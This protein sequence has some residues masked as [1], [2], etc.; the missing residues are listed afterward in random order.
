M[1]DIVHAPLFPVA[2]TFF[3]LFL[4]ISALEL[5]F[6]FREME[7]PR[8]ITKPFCVLLLALAFLFAR[9]EGYLV[10]IGLGYIARK[11]RRQPAQGRGGALESVFKLL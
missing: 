4:A 10:Y 3:V 5:V 9:P 11:H 1:N 8:K 2:A 7:R 6:C